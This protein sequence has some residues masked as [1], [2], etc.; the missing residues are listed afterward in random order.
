[1]KF[2]FI[3][4]GKF[5]MG[6]PPDEPGR[7]DDERQH[8]ANISK[9]FYMQTTE[10]TQG[11][12]KRVMEDNP[13]S[14]K[15]C[16]NDCPVEKVSWNDAQQ[17]I[18]KLNQMEGKNKYRL[19]TEAE[20]EYA[21]RAGSE[22]AYSFGAEVDKLGKY[23]WY[24]DSSGGETKPVGKKLP[25]AWGLYDMH[26]N[27]WEWVQDWYGDYPS[28][29]VADPKGPDRGESRVLRGGSWL[30]YA[31]LTRSAS[32]YGYGPDVRLNLIGFRVARDF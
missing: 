31:R 4:A 2:V 27:V 10:L 25:N 1:M 14:F 29:S 9:P 12:W 20:W 24:S 11:Q 8:E 18:E 19:P 16:G 22:T 7:D 26:G 5:V 23:A 17:F 15:D 28:N 32:R 13:S 21:C 6:S 30:N 3:P